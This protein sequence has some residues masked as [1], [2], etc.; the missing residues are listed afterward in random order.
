MASPTPLPTVTPIPLLFEDE[1]DSDLSLWKMFHGSPLIQAG[2][3][4]LVGSGTEKAEIQSEYTLQSGVLQ[5]KI[6]SPNWGREGSDTSFGFEIW[7]ETCHSAVIF[8]TSGHLAVLRPQPD[9]SNKCSGDPTYQEYKPISNW[10]ILRASQ[11]VYLILSWSPSRVT[12]NVNGDDSTRG[13]ASYTGEAIPTVPLRVRLNSDLNETYNID[14]V[15]VYP[16]P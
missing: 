8:K 9:T 13:E 11:T 16:T 6:E 2:K 14:Y 12:L 10:N 4:V 7:D 1:F 15:R 5:A 3:L